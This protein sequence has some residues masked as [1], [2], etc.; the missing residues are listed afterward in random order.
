EAGGH[1]TLA[2]ADPPVHT[3]HR[4][5]VFPELVARRMAALRPDIEALAEAHLAKALTSPQFEVMNDLANAIPIRVVSQLIGFQAA[6]PEVLLAAAFESTAMLAATQPL[7]E[8]QATMERSVGV[9]AWISDQLQQ[10]VDRGGDGIL[11]AIGAAVAA[12][13]LDF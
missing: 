12:G 10:S 3:K 2:V 8:I 7:D 4:S 11:G 13:D 5:T 1:Q 6:D 9:I